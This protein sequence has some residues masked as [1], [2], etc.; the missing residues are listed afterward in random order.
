LI[1]LVLA[2]ANTHKVEEITPLLAGTATRLV[3]VTDLVN[4]WELEETGETLEENALLKARAAAL[5][6]G[7]PA[8][9]DDTGLFVAALDETPGVRSSRY[10]G[11]QCSYEDNRGKLL[12]ALAGVEG[13]ARQARFRTVVALACPDGSER[14]FEGVLEGS[15]ATSPR[16]TGGFGYDPVFLLPCGATLAELSLQAKNEVSHRAAA[17]RAF[18]AWLSDRG[19]DRICPC[20]PRM[21]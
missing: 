7:M 1:E 15:I 14:V 13:E 8:V 11:P 2:T 17:F 6:T 3:P 18:T 20:D 4:G 12:A 19:A 21:G 10:A 9:G 5:A 16:G